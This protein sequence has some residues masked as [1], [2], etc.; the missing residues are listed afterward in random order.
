LHEWY[1]RTQQ[2]RPRRHHP[3]RAEVAKNTRRAVEFWNEGLVE[4]E[5]AAVLGCARN[6]ACAYLERG[7]IDRPKHNRGRKLS[8]EERA[9]AAEL[10]ERLAEHLSL[11]EIADELG[12]SR[13]FVRLCLDN[14]RRAAGEDT[15]PEDEGGG[16]LCAHCGDAFNPR[17]YAPRDPSFAS[18]RYCSIQCASEQAAEGYKQALVERGLLGPLEAAA[19]LELS[20]ARAQQLAA[21]GELTREWVSYEHQ[22]RPGWGVTEEA[23]AQLE[24]KWAREENTLRTRWLEPDQAVVMLKSSGRLDAKAR[25]LGLPVSAVEAIVR[26]Q[27]GRRRSRLGRRRRG[28]KPRTAPLP[29]HHRWQESFTAIRAELGAAHEANRAE[30]EGLAN[31]QRIGLSDA[32]QELGFAKRDIDQP[33]DYYAA[34]VLAERDWQEHP[35]LREAYPAA[36]GDTGAIDPAYLRP[37]AN[38]I[39]MAIKRLQIAYTENSAA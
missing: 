10:V 2:D 24:R 34:Q 4:T 19:R 8:T 21:S 1:R 36:K 17:V 3:S 33:S 29:H 14:R 22:R 25:Q 35:E 31:S 18:Q 12:V 7:G 20:P 30:A 39:L 28:P 15:E 9:S 38:A 5:I 27:V 26:D 32:C 37:A 23:I 16:H 11:T 6:T 13:T